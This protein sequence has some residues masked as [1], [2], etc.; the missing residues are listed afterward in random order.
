MKGTMPDGTRIAGPFMALKPGD[1]LTLEEKVRV[2]IRTDKRM[3]GAD[4]TILVGAASGE[5]K[6]RGQVKNGIQAARAVELAEGTTGVEKVIDEL[7]FPE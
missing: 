4:V 1:A 2:R 6:L 7:T 3:S 5:V